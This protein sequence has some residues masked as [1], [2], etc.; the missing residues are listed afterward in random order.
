M[1]R[2]KSENYYD[3]WLIIILKSTGTFAFLRFFC[4]LCQE[5]YHKT[6]QDHS[7]E[8][9]SSIKG[10]LLRKE[11]RYSGTRQKQQTPQFDLF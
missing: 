2:F 11:F 3:Y 10:G 1:L 5:T 9:S 4:D 6:R 8:Q 7:D